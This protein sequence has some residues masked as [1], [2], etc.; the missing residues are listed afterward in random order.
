MVVYRSVGHPPTKGPNHEFVLLV[1]DSRILHDI[2]YVPYI[3]R[4][5]VSVSSVVNSDTN[6]WY[7]LW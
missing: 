2:S 7:T 4:E 6:S 5:N 3:E 1:G